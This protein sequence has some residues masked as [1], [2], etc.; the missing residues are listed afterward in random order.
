MATAIALAE[1]KAGLS[2]IVRSVK[3]HESK[4]IVT[5]RGEPFAQIVPLEKQ[6]PKECKGFGILKGMR[7]PV[8]P[9]E[10]KA[11]WLEAMEAKHA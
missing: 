3:E 10:E 8:S 1:A 6:A 11:A 7:P 2:S 9:G 5:V 4:Y